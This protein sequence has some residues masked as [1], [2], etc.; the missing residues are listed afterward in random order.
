MATWVQGALFVRS[1]WPDYETLVELQDP[2]LSAKASLTRHQTRY[3]KELQC[4]RS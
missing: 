2:P 3:Q 1:E 4:L